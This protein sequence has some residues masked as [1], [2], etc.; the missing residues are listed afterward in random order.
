MVGPPAKAASSISVVRT[1]VWH[2]TWH[3]G[4][5]ITHLPA[6]VRGEMDAD[7]NVQAAARSGPARAPVVAKKPQPRAFWAALACAGV[8]HAVLIAGFVRSLPQRQMGEKDGM[9]EGVS[10]AMVDA[11]DLVSSNTL[12]KEG[13][14]SS[15]IRPARP[16][17]PTQEEAAR[18]LEEPAPKTPPPPPNTQAPEPAPAHE[19]ARQ[20]GVE[21]ERKEEAP[22]WPIDPQ[23]LEA[24]SPSERMAKP[25][26]P[27]ATSK[28]AGKRPEQRKAPGAP[29]QLSLPDTPIGSGG[30]GTAFARPAGITRSGEN[31]EFG[32]GVI[33][34]LRKT[35]PDMDPA[36]GNVTV[37]LLLSQDGN[38]L[39]VHLVKSSGN[40]VMDQSVVFAVRQSSFPFPPPNAPLVD[41]TFVVT[42]IYR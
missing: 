3:R 34:A 32:R 23:A 11:A 27:D 4:H 2:S 13:G 8:L 5:T 15:P 33:R 41:R 14:P 20:D 35:M 42:Y 19:T 7:S 24:V 21:K 16:V 37:R 29:L 30:G 22:A 17:P 26:E 25:R 31:D 38:L 28:P 12:A 39:E 40:P 36:R 9:P 10:V 18:L 6:K 1:L